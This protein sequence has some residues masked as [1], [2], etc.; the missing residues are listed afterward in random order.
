MK[1]LVA[2]LLVLAPLSVAPAPV[3]AA[4]NLPLIRDAEIEH[5]IRAYSAPIFAAAGIAANDV[6]VHI[7]N[8]PRINAFVAGGRHMFINTGLLMGA[9]DPSIVIGVIAH[10][11]GHIVNNHLIRLRAAIE[12]AQV[13][14]IITFILAGAAAV[15]ARDG[16][17]AG[18]V[19]SLGQRITAGTLFQYT[20]G[21]ETEAD[22]FA[23]ETLDR[24]GVTA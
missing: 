8:D 9:N 12:E 17:A 18:A 10:E 23:L 15:A 1:R 20:Q 7:V 4:P 2:M 24:M 22:R 14:Q 3:R 19:I 6:K 5:I 13:R 21:M 16:Q 11:T